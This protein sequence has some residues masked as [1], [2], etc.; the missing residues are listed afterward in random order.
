MSE[1]SEVQ[2]SVFLNFAQKY[3]AISYIRSNSDY[4]KQFLSSVGGFDQFSVTRGGAGF[5]MFEG[6]LKDNPL[7][8]PKY[9]SLSE[10]TP[11]LERIYNIDKINGRSIYLLLGSLGGALGVIFSMNSSR[12]FIAMSFAAC[13]TSAFKYAHPCVV[14][15]NITFAGIDVA[16]VGVFLYGLISCLTYLN[17]GLGN[18]MIIIAPSFVAMWQI[19][20]I[21]TLSPSPCLPCATI[22]GL[23]MC[24]SLTALSKPCSREI[25]TK[26]SLKLGVI[27]TLGLLVTAYLL[28]ASKIERPYTNQ[29][30]NLASIK[31]KI[32]AR[33]KSLLLG[34]KLS[35]IGVKIA[36]PQNG[37]IF[38]F[39]SPECLPCEKAREFLSGVTQADVVF[40][41]LLQQPDDKPT[42][43]FFMPNNRETFPASPT[44]LAVNDEG[45]IR[46]QILG[47]SDDAEW[48]KTA[49]KQLIG[50]LEPTN[51]SGKI[52]EKNN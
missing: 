46:Y 18:L 17:S 24:M 39:G 23:N 21:M 35:E 1:R 5:V 37:A 10:I 51:N 50:S 32:N 12:A 11:R 9:T 34:K 44:I 7:A 4:A 40:V 47:W 49:M 25:T 14:C 48:Q 31:S 27:F 43:H 45:K 22:L 30:A 13:L 15:L 8:L 16:L 42:W 6:D 2:D 52:N 38:V 41:Q 19:Y 33:E 26:T 36:V 3:G 28:G 20:S 29:G